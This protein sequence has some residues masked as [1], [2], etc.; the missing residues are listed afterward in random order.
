MKKLIFLV[1][2]LLMIYFAVMSCISLYHHN[3]AEA[4]LWMTV[5]IFNYIT[6]V[7]N[8]DWEGK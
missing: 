7:T 3:I 2:M 5:C 1:A 6:V 8:K 4:T